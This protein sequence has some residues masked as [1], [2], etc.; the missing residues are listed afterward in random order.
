MNLRKQHGHNRTKA[1]R[2]DD[3]WGRLPLFGRQRDRSEEVTDLLIEGSGM[4]ELSRHRN[5]TL[6]VAPD[7]FADAGEMSIG[8]RMA[9]VEEEHGSHSG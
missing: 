9:E 4:V 5:D 7:E 8:E 3:Q 2:I 6:D 1:G